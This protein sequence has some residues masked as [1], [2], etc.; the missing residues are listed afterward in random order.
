VVE[1]FFSSDRVF[2]LVFFVSFSIPAIAFSLRF[3]R[4]SF[5]P[6][7]PEES[8][9]EKE[10]KQTPFFFTLSQIV[11]NSLCASMSFAPATNRPLPATL[12]NFE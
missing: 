6:E 11:F 10:A 9:D 7:A 8:R 12:P 4:A 2:E 3:S 1:V 5:P